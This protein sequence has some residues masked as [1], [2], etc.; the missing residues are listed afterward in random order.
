MSLQIIIDRAQQIEFDRKKIV[1]QSISRSQ[2]LKTA[3]RASAVP[4]RW[5]VSPPGNMKYS[6]SRDIVED[7]MSNDRITET[8]VNLAQ[9]SYLSAYRGEL[10]TAQQANLRITATTT[11]SVTI[12]VLPSLGDTLTA[13]SYVMQAYAFQ[14]ST[15]V[16]YNRAL[17]TGRTDFLITTAELDANWYNIQQGDILSTSTYITGGQTI[18]AITRDYITLDGASFSRIVMSSAPN[19]STTA[20]AMT[21]TTR[22]YDQAVQAARTTTVTNTTYIFKKGDIIQPSGSRYPYQITNDVQRGSGSS[23]I[24]NL[25]RALITSE[26]ITL[27]NRNLKIGT[28]ATWRMVVTGLPNTVALPYDRM[29]W[30]GEFEL[31]EKII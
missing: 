1:G 2:R 27:T 14:T 13:R 5:I 7:I 19:A 26:G 6:Q 30:T 15:S 9:A 24:A 16:T 21:T 8:E 3:E 10:T 12:D 25:H 29:A 28:S 31:I 17:D 23:V 22:I 20:Y 4:W 11:A 18:S